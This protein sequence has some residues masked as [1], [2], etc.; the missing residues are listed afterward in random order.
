MQL[1]KL[2][3]WLQQKFVHQTHIFCLRLPERKLPSG[4]KIEALNVKKLGDHKYKLVVKSNKRAQKVLGLLKNEGVMYMTQVVDRKGFIGALVVPDRGR[5]FTYQ[6]LGRALILSSLISVFFFL[7]RV[8]QN[9]AIM[10][11]IKSAVNELNV[12]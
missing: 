12:N 9:E 11:K 6:L 7:Y 10:S 2:D 1:T 8:S 4:I 5:S 3:H